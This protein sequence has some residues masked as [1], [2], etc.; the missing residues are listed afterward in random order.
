MVAV[1]DALGCLVRFKILP[2]QAHDLDAVPSLLE[3]LPFEAFIGDKASGAD[4]LLDD[5]R[6]RGAQA[7]IPP[8]RNR[9]KPR[10]HDREMCGRRH[11]VEN[12]FAKIKEFRSIAT[13]YDKTDESFAA[14]IYLIAGVIAAR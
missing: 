10:K 13:R 8:K 6:E 3:G 12:F 1:T 9:K 7:V 11:T 4:W 5:L 14:G 2:G